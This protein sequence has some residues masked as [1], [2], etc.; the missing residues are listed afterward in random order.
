MLAGVGDA[1][2][3]RLAEVGPVGEYLVDGALA[4]RLPAARPAGAQAPLG[5]L[6]RR[7]QLPCHGERRSG[8]GERSKFIPRERNADPPA[9]A[10]SQR[11][12][13]CNL[14][15]TGKTDGHVREETDDGS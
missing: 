8:L 14:E 11:L 13:L 4:S 7:I 10:L 3:H 1:L 15:V 12:E 6:A 9:L 2:V 5:H